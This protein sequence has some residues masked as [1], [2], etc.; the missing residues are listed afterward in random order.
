[1][2]NHEAENY[3]TN[4]AWSDWKALSWTTTVSCLGGA[5]RM[6]QTVTRPAARRP[7]II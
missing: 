2:F 3:G 4:V 1:M 6:R 5:R 7:P